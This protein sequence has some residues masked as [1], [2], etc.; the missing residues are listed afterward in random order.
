LPDGNTR[1]FVVSGGSTFR[2]RRRSHLILRPVDR[3]KEASYREQAIRDAY[4]GSSAL[5]VVVA[6]ISGEVETQQCQERERDKDKSMPQCG[7]PFDKFTDLWL[8][9]FTGVLIVGG[10]VAENV[11]ARR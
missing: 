11:P 10:G 1:L 4:C 8:V 5:C 9:V 6:T 2:G 7:G 3:Q